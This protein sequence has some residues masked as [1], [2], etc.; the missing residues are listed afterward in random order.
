[1][2]KIGITYDKVAA[3]C[4]T[5]SKEGQSITARTILAQTGGSPNHVLKH[6]QQWRQQQADIAMAALEEELSPQIKH[7]ILAEAARKTTQVKQH[8]ASQIAA[9]SRQWTEIQE[10]LKQSEL[11]KEKLASDLDKAHSKIIEQEKQQ[12]VAHQRLADAED[13]NKETERLYRESLL[14]HERVHTE[15]AMTEKQKEALEKRIEN[16]E[17]QLKE[18]QAGKHQSDLEIAVLKAA[19]H[20]NAR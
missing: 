12:A 8:F 9:A 4:E 1:M 14:V 2:A 11:E 18:A 3:V 17:Q 13:R 6:W 10:L 16:L 7:A 20:A 15:K 5:L 19:V